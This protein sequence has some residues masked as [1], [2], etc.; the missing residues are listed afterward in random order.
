[1]ARCSRLARLLRMLN[2]H[3]FWNA[4]PGGTPSAES[5][6]ETFDLAEMMNASSR[7]FHQMGKG[8]APGECPAGSVPVIKK[9]GMVID[10]QFD[11]KSYHDDG[12]LRLC[13]VASRDADF[14]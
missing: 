11:E 6:I 1:M 9:N 13:V 3:S 4:A 8:F 12:S 5:L 2:Q 10:C 14:S 7:G